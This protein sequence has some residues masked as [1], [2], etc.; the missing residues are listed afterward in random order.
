MRNYENRNVAYS[1]VRNTS[2]LAFFLIAMS[3]DAWAHRMLHSVRRTFAAP[4]PME[5]AMSPNQ[6]NKD[7]KAPDQNKPAEKGQTGTPQ[8][9][10]KQQDGNQK[11]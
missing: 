11:K 3:I 1:G 4:Q 7:Q 5:I 10:Q 6:P 8:K 2:C 9:D